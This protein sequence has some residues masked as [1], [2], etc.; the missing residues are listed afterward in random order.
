[1]EMHHVMSSDLSAVGYEDGTLFIR[2]NSGGL[3][4]YSNVPESVYRG[5]MSATS[6]G[7]YFHAHIKGVYPYARIG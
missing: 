6:H 7:R 1:M 5:L 3:Y 4:R 2:F